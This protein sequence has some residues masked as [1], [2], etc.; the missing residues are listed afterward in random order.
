[1]TE[2]QQQCSKYGGG[3]AV[4]G[5]PPGDGH[6]FFTIVFESGK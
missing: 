6:S 3:E 4:E 5:E 1:M 2:T